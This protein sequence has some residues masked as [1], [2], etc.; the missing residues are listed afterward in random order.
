MQTKAP[1]TEQLTDQLLGF[2]AYLMKTTQGGVFQVAGELDLTLSQLRAL[3]FLAYGDHAPA[4]SELA[5][6]VGLSVAATGRAVDSLVRAD[7]VSRREDEADRRIKRLALTAHGE[8]MLAQIGAARREGLRQFAEA[9]DD[10]ARTQFSHA[11]S[12][13][14]TGLDCGPIP[15]ETSK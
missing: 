2:M 8:E 7:L 6:A 4:L 14:P 13:I 11:L 9:L 12:L 5:H 10:D 15:S 3:F 1:T